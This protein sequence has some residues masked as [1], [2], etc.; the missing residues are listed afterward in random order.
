VPQ[1]LLDSSLSKSAY[2]AV[3]KPEEKTEVVADKI[4][5]ASDLQVVQEE[6]AKG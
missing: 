5:E 1:F 2:V 6:E 4:E 3:E